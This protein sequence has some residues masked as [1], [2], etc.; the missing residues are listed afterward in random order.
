MKNIY[1]LNAGQV[2]REG[3]QLRVHYRDDRT[4]I[5]NPS[6]H[7]GS[8]KDIPILEL[9]GLDQLNP[10]NDRQRDGNFDFIEGI[11]IDTRNGNI[12]FPVLEPFG[13]RLRSQFEADET[14][15][16]NKFVYDTLYATTRADAELVAS[17]N[18]FFILGSFSGGSSS[19]IVLPGINIAENSVVVT[20]GNT[21][22]TEGLDYSVDYNLGRVRILNEGIL[23]SGKTIQISYEKA[24][25][26]NFQTRWLTG[27]RFDYVVNERFNIGATVLHLNERPGGITRFAV[28]DE[29]TRNTKYG[30]DINYRE[31]SRLLTKMI[32]FIP[33][34]NTKE[35]SSITF[36]GEFAQILPGTSN[37][38]E[39]KGTSYL[40]DFENAVTPINLGGWPA[41]K[42]ASTPDPPGANFDLT[43]ESGSSL[44]INYRRAK[45]AWYTI[46]NSVFY[47]STGL[48][49]RPDNIT[50][51][52]LRNHYVKA[53]L[54]QD[55]FR[56]QDRNLVVQ[57]QQVF[58]IA[59]FP[60]ERGPYN[61]NPDLTNRGLLKEP[62]KNWAG[63]T[64][65]I[66]NEVDFDKTNVEYL[67]FWLMDPFIGHDDGNPN[68][69]VI[70]G[71]FNENN[72][73]GGELIFNLGSVSEDV[74][75]DGKH[76]FENGLPED[77]SYEEQTTS[78]EW[79]YVTTE[80]FL[81]DFFVN[82][83]SA[84][85]NQDVGLDGVRND[86]EEDF[87]SD[88]INELNL[89]PDALEAIL[90]DPSADNF[91]YYLGENL[92]SRNA[93]I[94]QRYKNFNGLDG[95]SP[96]STGGLTRSS[97][98]EPD[99]EDLNQDNTIQTLEEYYEY[100]LNLQPG[101]LDVGSEN[102]VDKIVDGSGEATWYLVRIP[103]RNPDRVV[104]GINGFKT[105][106]YVRMY[107]TGF[108]QPV[109]LRMAKLQLVG[110][111][112]RKYR[113]PLNEVGLDEVPEV[114]EED[115]NVSVVNIEENSVGDEFTNP[116]RVPPGLN[117]DRD[118][119]T[120]LNR[121]VNE[122]SLQVC[123]KDLE[124]KDSRAVYKNVSYDLINYG[125]L[126][127]FFHAEANNREILNDDEVTAFLRFGTDFTE[128]YYEIELPLKVTPKDVT[129]LTDDALRRILWPAENEIDISINELLGLKSERNRLNLDALVPY[130]TTTND[131]RYR[132]TV[133]G[134][135]D[136]STILTMMIGVRN[137]ESDDRA[138]KSVCIW[139]NELRVTDFDT[140]KGW[141]ANARISAKLADLGT[142]T[143]STKYV[144]TGF[145]TI[146]QRIS[147]RT[148]QE[149]IQYDISANLNLDKFLLP[150]KTGLK[151]PMFVSYEN[152]RVTPQFDPLD[153]DVPLEASL[154][155][156]D[157]D[158][159]RKEYRRLVEDRTTRKSINFTNVRKEKVKED[160]KSHI[161][162][163]ENFS[164]S[165][166]YSEQRSSNINTETLLR[167]QQSG[168][169]AYNYSP[170]TISIQ[171]FGSVGFLENP[172][173]QL[174]KDINFSPLPN[175]LSA[176]ADLSRNFTLTQL[177][178]DQLTT[179][180]ISPF[181][182]R[183]FTFNRSYNLRW[184][185]FKSLSLDYSATANAV[186]DEPDAETSPLDQNIN[187]SDEF[188]F[189]WDQIR[190]LGRMKNFRQDITAT[191]RL[192][193]DKIPLT[194]WLSVDYRY[195]AGYNWI[196]GS[197]NQEDTAGN[198]F[199]HTIQNS[200]DQ[201]YTGKIDMVKLY[202]KV[203]FLQKIN[204]PQR[205]SNRR[206]QRDEEEE[207]EK[208]GTGIRAIFRLLMSLR[209]INVSYGIRETTALPG[210]TPTA[211]LAGLDTTFE[212]PGWR[213]ILGDQ[214]PNIRFRAA[215]NGW[216]TRSPQLTTPFQQ[217]GGTDLNLRASLEPTSDLKIQLEASRTT[218]GAYQE[219]FRYNDTTG[220]YNSLTPSRSG[221]YSISYLTINTAFEKRTNN[222]SA[223]FERFTENISV[224]QDRLELIN[225]AP[226]EYN[227][228]SQ[229]VLIPAFLAAYSGEQA[230]AV[231]LKPFPTIP[232]PN[233][234]IDYAGLSK[235][236]AFQEIFSSVNVTHSYRS[237]FNI[238][239]YTN[240]LAYDDNLT[241]D[242]D[243]LDY[244][245]ATQPNDSGFYV[246][247]YLINQVSIAE[248]F[249]PLIGVNIRTKSNL[250]ARFDYKQD[251][252]LSLNLS[253][254]Q[255][256]ETTNKDFSFDFGYTKDNLK[257]PFKVQGRTITIEN[258]VT[259]RLN[260][261]YR[262]SKTVQR[263]INDEDK[264]TN[265]NENFQMRPQIAYKINNQL[266]LTAYFERSIT[267]PRVGSFRRATTA[268][269]FQLRF[270]LTQ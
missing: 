245:L 75:R 150:E 63:I 83:A 44:G 107:M 192:P 124:D 70:D 141:A 121:R 111:Q 20:A 255:V 222:S 259:F 171:P 28:G 209:S 251:R 179:E 198:F 225:N 60:H 155:S 11:T 18:K 193:L 214:D 183:L 1:N 194:D 31:E 189:V 185:I 163:I 43:S 157:D 200:R 40:D 232:L 168:G 9:V 139:A 243:I 29:P 3:F 128:N 154:E 30:F 39:G 247:V 108:E 134:R 82:S 233:W 182:E 190:D 246:P 42:I 67:E 23:N 135:P 208:I 123:V 129:G 50:E 6:L 224:I 65:A 221:S 205:R 86:L 216:L 59:Y 152:T 7:E 98:V 162:D 10:N 25:L 76:A 69:R 56:Q 97:T 79:G 27:A 188:S 143:A 217:T 229:D 93:K 115:F 196:A 68:G 12:I 46:D 149:S 87:F 215:E 218:N 241:L 212:A 102:I 138:S 5:D 235:I 21:P 104:G 258:D 250:T 89:S 37:I 74:M 204:K 110:S 264:V 4:G 180:G 36:S 2:Q 207:P 226:Y 85:P 252:N 145:G 159:E 117:R 126:K 17:K 53:V 166:A 81:T 239:N 92:D 219:I 238:N 156:F 103:I 256:T 77:G 91:Q 203:P 253:N 34:V 213:F 234:R 90:S 114:A 14:S 99:N 45:L 26:F 122:Q 15:L 240:T 109:V 119:T 49:N 48:N 174:I 41:W 120:I 158:E 13:D 22:L 248:Q 61:Y 58:D 257:L 184:N 38:V 88:Y 169:L 263:K 95:N 267:N 140:N 16:I 220:V 178:N 202:N 64:R 132:I 165:Y 35:M 94:L 230:G 265:G 181:Y 71:I 116:Y 55:I 160:A 270:N 57:N 32:D 199:G 211:Y 210:F 8:L 227:D 125:R 161:Y 33:L 62:K 197:L 262:D 249:A 244:P 100:R 78:N 261:T 186:I 54:P 146:Q 237:V 106:R 268:F 73:T 254:A 96:V 19:E 133:K 242:N 173:L 167:T 52:D 164:V 105:I 191:Y 142:V 176:R 127:M 137:P 118:N 195:T 151:V 177:Y 170:S 144:S 66:T 113:E 206:S 51:D 175:T 269:G 228:I 72:S 236:P 153:P 147:E 131:G 84:R 136:M 80:Q 187:T 266:D 101:E 112:W 201:S 130:T 260:L 223:A 148:R 231:S 172:Y 47:R 24:D